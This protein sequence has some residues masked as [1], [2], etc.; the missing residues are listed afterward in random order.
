MA[1]R[2]TLAVFNALWS[3]L[4][5]CICDP[6]FDFRCKTINACVMQI[7]DTEPLA[8]TSPFTIAPLPNKA[9]PMTSQMEKIVQEYRGI[10]SL[11]AGLLL[12]LDQEGPSE[13]L[14][15][16]LQDA[17]RQ[18]VRTQLPPFA[19]RLLQSNYLHQCACMSVTP[20]V[21]TGH[22]ASQLVCL[23]CRVGCP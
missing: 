12:R 21:Q 7:L 22:E 19:R 20:P 9:Q 11:M 14:T 23:G 2:Q 6:S 1:N 16:Q 15:G 3:K 18:S 10:V 5:V 13:G 4:K 17:A 8:A